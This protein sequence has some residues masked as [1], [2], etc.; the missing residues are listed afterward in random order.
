MPVFQGCKT[1]SSKEVWK[2]PDGQR[3]IYE[4][5]FTF[6]GKEIK[7]STFSD[8]ILE[9]GWTG[10]LES[11]EKNDRTFVKQHREE[12]AGG[13]YS[14]GGGG[15]RPMADPFTMYLSYAKDLSVAMLD[16]LATKP[17]SYEDLI[18]QTRSEEH[19]SE[20]QSLR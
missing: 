18:K 20:L 2:S 11:Y 7:A 12:Q 5:V 3:T 6:E 16:P 14:R 17:K 4:I 19:T 15:S 10:D 8:K 1:V 13:G 9:T